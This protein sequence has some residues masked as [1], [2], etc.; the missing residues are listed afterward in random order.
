V[1]ARDTSSPATGLVQNFVAQGWQVDRRHVKGDRCR[2][3]SPPRLEEPAAH[4]RNHL[5]NAG[6]ESEVANLIANDNVNGFGYLG[7]G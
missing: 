7:P 5:D 6:L 2:H 4:V 3:D 1:R